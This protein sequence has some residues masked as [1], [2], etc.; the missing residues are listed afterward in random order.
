MFFR[1]QT[2]PPP[3]IMHT[4][5]LP[6][7]T[8]LGS[9]SNAQPLLLFNLEVGKQLFGTIAPPCERQEGSHTHAA[10]LTWSPDHQAYLFVLLITTATYDGVRVQRRDCW[11][12]IFIRKILYTC[13][14]I[15]WRHWLILTEE[16][17]FLLLPSQTLLL[18]Q[19]LHERSVKSL[20]HP[21]TCLEATKTRDYTDGLYHHFS[22][23]G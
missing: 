8:S 21:F 1:Q 4:L 19:Q 5:H 17:D 7:Q 2:L 15:W 22:S 23:L 10:T 13:T 16:A 3:N 11:F 18:L 14:K 12:N 6:T 9:T 20:T